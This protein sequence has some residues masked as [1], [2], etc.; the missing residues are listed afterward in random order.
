MKINQDCVL[1][2]I[3]NHFRVLIAAST[4]LNGVH[5]CTLVY[6]KIILLCTE[7]FVK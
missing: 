3:E 2:C 4:G 5:L 6:M 7:K 1:F